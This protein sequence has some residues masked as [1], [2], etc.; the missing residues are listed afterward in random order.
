MILRFILKNFLSFKEST[1]FNAFP[2]GIKSKSHHKKEVDGIEILKAAAIYGANGAG[3]SNFVRGLKFLQKSI[4]SGKLASDKISFRLDQSYFDEEPT[5]IDVEFFYSGT[6]FYYEIEF[7]DNEILHEILWKNSNKKKPTLIFKR[8]LDKSKVKVKLG[9]D[10]SPTEKDKM[11][12]TF[13][14]E[15]VIKNNSLVISSSKIHK[16]INDALKVFIWFTKHL[17][18]ISPKS[19]IRG[20]PIKLFKEK[21]FQNYINKTLCSLDTGVKQINI[22]KVS[23]DTFF[24]EDDKEKIQDIK[25]RIEEKIEQ[26]REGFLELGTS[27]GNVD[28][29]KDGED[30]FAYKIEFIHKGASFKN[31]ES[32]NFDVPEESEGTQRLLDLLPM[33]YGLIHENRVYVI[34]EIERSIHPILIKELLTKI[35]SNDLS[36]QLI[37]TTH[38]SILLDLEIFRQDE[39]WFAEKD[40]LGATSLYPLSDFKARFDLDVRK[41]YLNGR[42]GAIPFLGDLKALRLDKV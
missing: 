39:I 2:S 16:I 12:V 14:E 24:G 15:E 10:Y 26:K 18:I 19:H 37:F 22:K 8:G 7:Q 31:K 23:L 40:N 29:E 9:E 30:Y 42:F 6:F 28:V 20:L 11:W 5:K 38:E 25:R 32:L 41:G 36:G 4:E 13:L 27:V 21:K 35:L 17:I 3:K 33:T 1:E 34:D